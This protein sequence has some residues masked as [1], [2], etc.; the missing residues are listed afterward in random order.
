MQNILVTGGTGYIGSHTVVE[1]LNFNFNIIIIDNLANSNIKVLDRIKTI[2]NKEVKFIQLDICDKLG[3]DAVFNEYKIDAVVHFAGLKAV[4]ES[5]SQPLSY[6]HNNVVG[7]IILL[8][9]M[10][11][12]NVKKIVFSSSATVYGRANSTPITETFPLQPINPYGWTKLIIEQILNDLYNS[13]NSWNIALLR[14]FNPVGAHKS[15]LIGENPTG[16][17]NNLMPYISQTAVGKYPYLKIF[18]NDYNTPDGTGVRDYI[19]VVDLANG[20]LMALKHFA[21]TTALGEL[22]TLNLGTGVGHSVLEIIKTFEKICGKKIPY[23]FYPRRSGDIDKSFA[24]V[25]KAKKI[26][27]WSARLDIMDM[28]RDSWNWQI[29]N[30]D[31]YK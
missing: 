3:L 8:E 6:Y 31:G 10:K 22:I 18:G 20:H 15:G 16:I 2:T 25:V 4:G 24:A 9:I 7:S 28:C 27:G 29:K 30:P 1:L 11:K 23:N 13:D 21:K 5:V 26:L 17:P 14:Y 12:Y 19:H